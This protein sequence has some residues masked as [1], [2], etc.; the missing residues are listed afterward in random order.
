[1]IDDVPDP[2]RYRERFPEHGEIVDAV[3]A[4]RTGTAASR[5][6]A[7]RPSPDEET[8]DLRRADDAPAA[9]ELEGDAT[10]DPSAGD[11]LPPRPPARTI[12]GYEILGELGR[13]GMGVVY[14]AR[15]TA[16][17][18]MVALKLIR[19]AEFATPAELVRFQNEAEAVAQLDHP[20][21]VPIYEVGQHRG[22]RFFSMK[23]IEGASLDEETGG[24]RDRLPRGGP[25][26]GPR[27]GGR[28]PRPPA[29]DPPPRP[30]AGQHP[31]GRAGHAPCHGLRPGQADRFREPT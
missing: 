17:E 7:D 13:G 8:L 27:G 5:A 18:R 28:T 1:M 10:T 16:L 22:L 25:A 12:A 6:N 20:H 23:L 9:A 3:F 26:G 21:I 14:K 4:R 31:A 19:S 30:E 2:L 11:A 15:Q 29:R 24:L